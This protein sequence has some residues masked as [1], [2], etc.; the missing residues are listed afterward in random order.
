MEYSNMDCKK[1]KHVHEIVGST[2]TVS[3]CSECHNHRFATVSGEAIPEGC[4]HVHEVKFRT[5]FAD[6]HYH[7]FC[8]KSSPAI[9]VGGGK[10]VHFAKACTT[11]EDGH[12]HQFQVASL[13]DS[14]LDFK[15]K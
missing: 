6:G 2:D 15:C 8:G 3:E 5:D 7:E 10:H 9:D 4:S 14:P 11:F 12:K 1:Q 13:I